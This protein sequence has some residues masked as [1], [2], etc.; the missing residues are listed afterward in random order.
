MNWHAVAIVLFA[1][2]VLFT[3]GALAFMATAFEYDPPRKAALYV[4]PVVV[5]VAVDALGW[6]SREVV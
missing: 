1:A 2:S 6:C 5:G 3:I 4:I